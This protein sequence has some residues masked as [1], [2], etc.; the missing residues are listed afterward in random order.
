[1]LRLC[2]SRA[3]VERVAGRAEPLS[4]QNEKSFTR[5]LP[6]DNKLGPVPSDMRGIYRRIL[7]QAAKNDVLDHGFVSNWTATPFSK[8]GA[9]LSGVV[10]TRNM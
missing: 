9:S 3:D 6:E 10:A 4:I 1:M 5:D 7:G 2:R 8:G